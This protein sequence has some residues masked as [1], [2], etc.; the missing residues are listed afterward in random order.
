MEK[1]MK[2]VYI[3]AASILFLTLFAG[4]EEKAALK[5]KPL[6]AMQKQNRTIVKMASEAL[7]KSLPQKIDAYTTLMKIEARD[8]TLVYLFEVNTGA[9]SDEAVKKE[10]RIRMQKAVTRG[11]CNSSQRFLKVDINISYIYLSARTQNELFHFNVDRTDCF[12]GK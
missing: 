5:E 6:T 7:S 12:D 1:Q 8:E 3:V 11:I 4:A 2:R 10:D 9:K